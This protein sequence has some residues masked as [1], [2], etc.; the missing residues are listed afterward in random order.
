MNLGSRLKNIKERRGEENMEQ[1]KQTPPAPKGRMSDFRKALIWTAIPMFV[2]SIVSMSIV[3]L[4]LQEQGTSVGSYDGSMTL[5]GTQLAVMGAAIL[6]A[7][8][9]Q[10]VLYKTG[11]RQVA[12]GILAGAGI[13]FVASFVSCFAFV[14]IG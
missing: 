14:S 5:L 6:T 13:G 8:V 9:V 10:S 4:V 7:V 12:A 1:E 2:L 3:R 11:K